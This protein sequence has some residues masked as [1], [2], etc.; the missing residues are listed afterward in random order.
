MDT[1]GVEYLDKI[2]V[3]I[4]PRAILHIQGYSAKRE[5]NTAMLNLI[6][7]AAEEASPLVKPRA[8]SKDFPIAELTGESLTLQNGV[9][10]SIGKK[11]SDWWK[12]SK[13][14][15]IAICTIGDGL[16]KRLME[17]SSKGEHS[18]AL[19][20][21]IAGTVALGSLGD[22]VHQ[23]ICNRASSTGIEMGPFLNPGYREWPL[24]DQK[25][26]FEIMP[27]ADISVRLNE[28]CMMIPKKSVTF[29]AGAGVI[30]V[31]E[32]FN[33][34]RHCGLAKCPYRHIS[35]AEDGG[36]QGLHGTI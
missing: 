16:E 27:A 14:L 33:R 36:L 28:Q 1:T 32:H 15:V 22:Q 10:F 24:T 7:R 29:C 21:D 6:N 31:Q 19:N 5:P 34:C 4:D 23:H 25:I 2:E 3:T 13:S 9:R 35:R 12:G 17:L 20:L 26:I 8:I 18:A 30:E 11:I